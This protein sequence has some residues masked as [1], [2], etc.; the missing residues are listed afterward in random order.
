MKNIYCVLMTKYKHWNFIHLIVFTVKFAFLWKG[1][2]DK[3]N[4]TQKVDIIFKEKK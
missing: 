1:K 3:L 4:E 2:R